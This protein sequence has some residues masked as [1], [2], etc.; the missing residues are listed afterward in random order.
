MDCV[1]AGAGLEPAT[2][3][4]SGGEIRAIVYHLVPTSTEICTIR[5]IKRSKNKNCVSNLFLLFV[6]ATSRGEVT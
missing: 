5:A 3:G 1:V 4:F 6:L 2:R